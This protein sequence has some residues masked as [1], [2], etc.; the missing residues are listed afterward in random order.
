MGK[1]ETGTVNYQGDFILKDGK[2][3]PKDEFKPEP[4]YA[5]SKRTVPFCCFC[6]E[7]LDSL[8]M[9]NCFSE[10]RCG[11][12]SE[13]TNLIDEKDRHGYQYIPKKGISNA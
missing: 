8:D 13:Y 1:N 2:L 11:K 10:C 3:I 7:E 12:W 9:F 6:G 5:Q 4:F